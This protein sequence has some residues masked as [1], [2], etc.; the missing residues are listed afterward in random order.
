[1]S[2]YLLHLSNDG[3]Y[4]IEES[5]CTS[6][7]VSQVGTAELRDGCL[8]LT[9]DMLRKKDAGPA[10][11]ITLFVLHW[12]RRDYLIDRDALWDF[13]GDINAGF[14]PRSDERGAF[15]RLGDWQRKVKGS[16]P[17]PA[18]WADHLLAKPLIGKVME[19]KAK[20]QITINVGGGQQVFAGMHLWLADNQNVMV[21]VTAFTDSSCTAKSII[22]DAPPP[23]SRLTSRFPT[24]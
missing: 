12:G 7:W 18:P 23:G 14:E 3:R 6:S 19:V 13:V 21:E 8:Y 16:P 17:L 1:G 11:P 2:G 15:L 24:K 4:R 10:K 5:D 20:D 22:G 9:P